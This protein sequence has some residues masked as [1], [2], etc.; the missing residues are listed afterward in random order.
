MTHRWVTSRNLQSDPGMCSDFI[1]LTGQDD[2]DVFHQCYCC[3]KSTGVT[4]AMQHFP[5]VGGTIKMN[6]CIC[7]SCGFL[8]WIIDND[9]HD[10]V[11][12]FLQLLWIL[13]VES[14]VAKLTIVSTSPWD[15][16]VPLS[17]VCAS[18]IL[19]QRS[20]VTQGDIH[21]KRVM[22]VDRS[23]IEF[24]SLF[25]KVKLTFMKGVQ[26]PSERE[27]K[28]SRI[29]YLNKSGFKEKRQAEERLL[30]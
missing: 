28:K 1:S 21:H 17:F 22:D 20:T 12:I 26:T 6:H 13:F 16:Q 19:H 8:V 23:R 3:D 10:I 5:P 2:S 27:E 18:S 4:N 14:L 7:S 11:L 29:K 15:S 25:Q 30:Q 24:D 9:W